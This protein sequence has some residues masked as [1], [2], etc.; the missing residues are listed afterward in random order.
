MKIDNDC[1]AIVINSS[2]PEN[3]GKCVRVIKFIGCIE[4]IR[5]VNGKAHEDMWEID[6][7]TVCSLG[8]VM[9]ACVVWDILACP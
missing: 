9:W 8:R 2:V 4:G 3:V 6:T 1:L 7:P 5:G